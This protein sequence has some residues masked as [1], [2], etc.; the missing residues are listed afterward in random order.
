V[1]LSGAAC[2][3]AQAKE[4]IVNNFASVAVRASAFA[5]LPVSVV[6]IS[7]VAYEHFNQTREVY[8]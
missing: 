7:A 6:K 4:G 1:F 3:E 2:G 5:F 8:F